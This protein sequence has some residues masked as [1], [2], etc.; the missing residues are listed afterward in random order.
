MKR[1]STVYVIDLTK[2]EGDG[3]FPC[4]SCGVVISPEDKSGDKY[5]I[6]NVRMKRGD[7]LE[8][9]VI[10]CNGCGSVVHITGFGF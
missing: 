1:T 4:P 10:K 7:E 3:D 9:L 5:V 8:E 2:I 6:K